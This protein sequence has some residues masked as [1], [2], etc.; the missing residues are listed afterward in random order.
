VSTYPPSDNR[1][2][3]LIAQELNTRLES[4][5]VALFLAEEVVK[6]PEVQAELRRMNAAHAASQ[7]CGDRNCTQCWQALFTTENTID[8]GDHPCTTDP[9]ESRPGPHHEPGST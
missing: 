7:P 9:E 8:Q 3:H 5:R 6:A 4:W 1:L 2:A